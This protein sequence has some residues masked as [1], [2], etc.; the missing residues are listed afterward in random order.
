MIN[1]MLVFCLLFSA[2]AH[3]EISPACTKRDLHCILEKSLQKKGSQTLLQVAQGS[4][5]SI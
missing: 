5:G 4:D 3:M 1:R 2:C